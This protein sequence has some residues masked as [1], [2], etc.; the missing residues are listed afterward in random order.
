MSPDDGSLAEE[1][2][3]PECLLAAAS[4][5][6]A[7]DQAHQPR[8]ARQPVASGPHVPKK[9]PSTSG[10]PATGVDAGEDGGDARRRQA[11]SS[12]APEIVPEEGIEALYPLT[13]DNPN[14]ETAYDHQLTHPDAVELPDNHTITPE[15]SSGIAP[16]LESKP[17]STTE[18]GGLNPF[19]TL[20]SS[21]VRQTV[22][23]VVEKARESSV[24]S[25]YNKAN[26][27]NIKHER[28]YW[29]QLLIEYGA[30]TLFAAFVYFVL[31]G[32]PLWKGAVYWL[33]WLMEHKFV[34]QGG[35]AIVISL[36]TFYSFS[37]LLAT[38]EHDAPDSDFYQ[39]RRIQPTA[40]D[41]ALLIPC[42]RSA[43]VIRQTIEAALK[44]FPPSHIYVI[45]NGDSITPIDNTEEICRPYGVNHIWSPVGSKI[46]ALFVGCYAA[47]HF[48][49]VLLIDDDCVLP[50]TFPV[51]ISRLSPQ[52]RCIGY[53]IKVVAPD[54]SLGSYCQQAQ[55]LE[56]KLAGLQRTFAGRVGSATFPHGAISLWERSFL[57]DALEDHPGFSISEDWF[58][59]NS[60]RRLGGRIQMCSS[61]F[62]ETRAPPAFLFREGNQRRG[63][64]GEMTVFKQRFMRWNFFVVN[65]LR[66][67]MAYLFGS[68]K[69]GRWEIGAKLFV[70][71]E[72][73]ETVLSLLAPFVLPISLIVRPKFCIA[74][75]LSTLG[76]YLLNA[77]VFNEIHLR[78]KNERVSLKVVL[79]YYTPYKILIAFINVG[80]NYW[81]LFKYAKY[82]AQRHPKLGED[83]KAVGLVLKLEESAQDQHAGSSG[84]GRS[85]TV[86]SV[87]VHNRGNGNASHRSSRLSRKQSQK[88]S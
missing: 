68:W 23:N 49:Y 59:G 19:T 53:T 15:N 48:R 27:V 12:L 77:I 9:R 11:S 37:P 45:A 75:L 38:F 44:I 66:Y 51:V 65:G 64:F 76:L 50:P 82:F 34:F 81:S 29:V 35:W 78:L 47:K 6:Q 31:I 3:I 73:Y 56:Y 25:V 4:I 52:I 20:C 88:Q 67:N 13:E 70:I 14:I 2:I 57:R 62:V 85:M 46:V 55:D 26:L 40:P 42:F 28:Q 80:S 69:L 22:R 5:K 32:V 1:I 7:W 74:L 61:V 63:G 72:L 36:V 54:G 71:Q 8:L 16:I 21:P 33:Y 30:Y 39:T 41:T 43:S 84:L 24:L 17:P 86:R 58:L 60:C 83:H 10:Y 87:G 79:F 18:T